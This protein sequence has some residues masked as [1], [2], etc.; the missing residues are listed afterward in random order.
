MLLSLLGGEGRGSREMAVSP[1]LGTT[2]DGNVSTV[3]YSQD[4]R[5]RF[6]HLLRPERSILRCKE[7]IDRLRR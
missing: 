4:I 5:K 1:V 3:L 2:L 6:V 7:A